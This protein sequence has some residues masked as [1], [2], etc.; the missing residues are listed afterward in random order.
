VTALANTNTTSLSA[1]LSQSLKN[2]K[3]DIVILTEVIEHIEHDSLAIKEIF[4]LLKSNGLLILST[5]SINA[6]LN[7]L[8]LTKEFDKRVGHLRRYSQLDLERL[9]K[10]NN[11]KV[12]EIKKTEG[13]IRNFLFVNPLAGKL[14]RVVNRFGSDFVTYLDNISIKLFGE[15]NYII[16][17]KRITK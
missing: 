14:I 4:K 10:V 11:F 3:Y 16:I 2:R 13:I 6:P 1:I 9:L 12:E 8:G 15:S 5:P 17:A 7:K